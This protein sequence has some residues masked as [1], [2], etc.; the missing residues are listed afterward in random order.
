MRYRRA[1]SPFLAVQILVSKQK[2]TALRHDS[3]EQ[4]EIQKGKIGHN[5]TQLD[6]WLST[7]KVTALK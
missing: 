2:E 4:N 5:H 7:E 3:I 6:A 1:L